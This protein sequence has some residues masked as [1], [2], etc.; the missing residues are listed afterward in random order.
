[1]GRY[2]ARRLIGLPLTLLGVSVLA[3]VFLRLIPGDAIQTRLGTATVLSPEQLAH[4]RAY[5]GLDQ[6]LPVQYA[7]WLWS[8]VH[9]DLGYSIRTGQPAAVEI[10]R[11]LPVTVELAG[12]AALVALGLGVSLGVGSALRPNGVLDLSARGF[13]L[14]GLALPSFWMGTLLILVFARYL[15]WMPNT[16]GFVDL[17][18]DPV[19]N[20]TLILFPAITLGL[21]MAAV[22]MRTTRSAM[23][24]VLGADFIRTARAKGLPGILVIN[25]HALKNGMIVVVTILGIQISALLGGAIVVE[26]VFSVPGVGRLLL[27]AI[28]QRDYAVVQGAVLIIATLVVLT[29]TIVDILYGFLDPRIRYS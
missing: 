22:V 7:T 20:V 5:L 25:R 3:F 9:G 1:M 10:A 19:A 13:A 8:V 24:D 15:R 17:F 28:S 4:Q 14:V 18:Q 23:L 26:E 12:A 21:T 27:T 11:R 29:S 16:G 2:L 6:P